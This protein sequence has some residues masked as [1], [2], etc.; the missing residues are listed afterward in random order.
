MIIWDYY[1]SISVNIVWKFCI[2]SCCCLVCCSMTCIKSWCCFLDYSSFLLS[3][4][5]RCSC[6]C[7]SFIFH[8]C[9]R[10]FFSRKYATVLLPLLDVLLLLLF[11][12]LSHLSSVF[13][14][15]CPAKVLKS[16]VSHFRCFGT[17]DFLFVILRCFFNHNFFF[18]YL[19]KC[20]FNVTPYQ[21]KRINLKLTRLCLKIKN[22][23]IWL[24]W[25]NGGNSFKIHAGFFKISDYHTSGRFKPSAKLMI[26]QI[27]PVGVI[28]VN[29]LGCK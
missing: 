25:N 7:I 24:L 16:S 11:H 22:D 6:S 2:C 3:T 20:F 14:F 27:L 28:L 26:R 23:R 5:S 17:I 18:Y 8:F 12:S 13:S 21:E 10:L 1:C 4:S 9:M 29:F 15:L 19:L